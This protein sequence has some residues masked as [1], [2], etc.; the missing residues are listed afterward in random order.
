MRL[1]QEACGDH[2]EWD[3]RVEHIA[4]MRRG[5]GSISTEAFVPESGEVRCDARVR[6]WGIANRNRR[7]FSN[8]QVSGLTGMNRASVITTGGGSRPSVDVLAADANG[9]RVLRVD[10]LDVLPADEMVGNRI[11]DFDAVVEHSNARSNEQQVDPVCKPA[12]EHHVS[13]N[14]LAAGIDTVGPQQATKQHPRQSGVGET[15]RRSEHIW[16]VHPMIIAHAEG[17][18]RND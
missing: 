5:H 8:A 15:A 3:R 6:P 17:A 11:P 9:H 4:T 10:C 1:H 14:A 7:A 12:A 18:S 16:L 13:G 2:R